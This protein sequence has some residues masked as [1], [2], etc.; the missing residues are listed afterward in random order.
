MNSKKLKKRGNL[1]KKS[2][3]TTILDS[4]TKM[5]DSYQN[6]MQLYRNKLR[7]MISV[8]NYKYEPG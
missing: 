4:Y 5:L 8:P 3:Y 2:N 7:E 6:I 1:E